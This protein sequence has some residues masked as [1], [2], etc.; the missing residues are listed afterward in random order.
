MTLFALFKLIHVASAI[1]VMTGLLARP[2]A[3]IAA[4]RAPDIRILKAIADVSGRFEDLMI[5]PGLLAVIVTGLAAAL[6]GGFSLLGPFTGGPLWIFIPIV[7]MLLAVITTPLT[8]ARDRRWGQ[9]LQEAAA[10]GVMTDRLRAFLQRD[11]MVKRYAPDVVLAS[12]IVVLM[13][14]KPF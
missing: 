6:T 10:Q 12:L 9:A 8:L 2:V 14:L 3:L 5:A 13:V 11:T 1:W 7:L 4:R